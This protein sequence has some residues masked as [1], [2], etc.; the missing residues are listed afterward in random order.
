MNGNDRTHRTARDLVHQL[1]PN[2]QTVVRQK[3]RDA[4]RVHL[5]VLR[6]GIYQDRPRSRV[7]DGVNRCDEGQRGDEYFVARLDAGHEQGGVQ[8]GGAV[9]RRYGVLR[10]D[11]CGQFALET[12]HIPAD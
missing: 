2:G 1:S 5:R 3:C 9:D 12:I 10:A 11:N 4:A 6:F 8:R 7:A